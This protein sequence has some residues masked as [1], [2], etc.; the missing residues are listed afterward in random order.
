MVIIKQYK[1]PQRLRKYMDQ[2]EKYK[3]KLLRNKWSSIF[4]KLCIQDF[5]QLY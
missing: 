1:L 2:L 3:N 5:A 4:N